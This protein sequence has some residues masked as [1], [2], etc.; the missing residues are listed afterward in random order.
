MG[1][2]RL[3]EEFLYQVMTLA[4]TLRHL[5]KKK[6]RYEDYIRDIIDGS[7]YCAASL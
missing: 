4:A 5:K 1:L 6:Y 2:F 3:S 7:T